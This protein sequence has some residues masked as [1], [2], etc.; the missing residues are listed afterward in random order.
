MVV[1]EASPFE[2]SEMLATFLA[3]TPLLSESWRLCTAVAASAPR[4]FVIE[5]GVGGVMYVAF[6]GMEMAATDSSWRALEPLA[7]IGDV[8]L[9]SARRNKEDDPV[10]VHAG[11]LKLF[12]T[13]F[14][15]FQ[16]QM[17]A[18]MG[19]S[20]TKTIVIT[21]HSIG[22]ATASLSA[23]WLLSYLHHISCSTSVSVLCITFGS[24]MLGNDSFSRA[25]LKERWGGNFCHVVSKHDIM[26][27]LLFAPTTPYTAQ[28]NLLLQFWQQSTTAPGFGKL[29]VPVS[30]Q[31]QELFNVVMS[32]LDAAT[33]DG[34]G[35]TPILFHPFGSYL[36]VS[37]EGAVS[38]D[39]ST[40]VIKMMHLMF[41]SGSPAC[42]IE[43]HLK[44]GDY[45]KKLSLQFLSHK[46]SMQGNI[47]D[48]SYEAGLELAVQSLGLA[49]QDSAKECLKLTRRMG[50]SPTMNAAMLP[51]KLSK[52]VPYR[53]EIELY[54][55]WCDQQVDQ[56][57]YYD[58]FKRRRNSSK[59]MAMKINMNRHKLARFWNDVIEMWERNELPHDL[60]LREKWVNA[61]HFYKLL[62]EP[63]DIG[64]YYGKGMH[65][66]KGHYI[67]H[68]REKRYEVFDR[69]W[70]DGM[71]AAA[72][73]ENNER[74]TKF[75]S[76]TQ[77]SCFWARVE[78][79]TNW[80][81]SV[82]SESDTTKLAV[83][84]DNIEKFEKYAV[85]LINNKE[86][87]EDVLAKNS[88]YSTWVE[89]LKG[90]RELSKGEEV[91]T[92]H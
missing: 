65:R 69:W 5:Q 59:K 31:Q 72:A 77:D 17:L 76:L 14:D 29:A 84:W 92:Q 42:S 90:L 6:P 63:L 28:L 64:E 1:D 58:L 53:T 39:S 37:S 32:C 7:S 85:E 23:L 46:N 47:P 68:G 79:A 2:T 70:K 21:G 82:R 81:N 4:S 41:A 71:A 83:L 80:L 20:N 19:N 11:M 33:Q 86:V 89:D 12:S 50:P 61:S 3:S 36:F 60:A 26:P 10:M 43:D 16:N 25:I 15:S 67:L 74:R 51:I 40:A 54:K 48:S 62:V 8:T 18:L 78:E 38:V 35:S 66:T 49:K 52:V 13:F 55:S 75:A 44:Y 27:R 24:P 88:S 91:P 56:M 73:E 30:D 87:S 34:E 9:F 57:G 45:V 22:G